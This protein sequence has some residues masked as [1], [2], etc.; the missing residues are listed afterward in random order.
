MRFKVRKDYI[1]GGWTVEDTDAHAIIEVFSV[2]TD[3][4]RIAN[5]LNRTSA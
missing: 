4:Q 1:S 3:A 5:H 2:K